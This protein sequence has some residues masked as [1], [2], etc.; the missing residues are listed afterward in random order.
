M[1]GDGNFVIY[2]PAGKPY[3]A[4]NTAGHAGAFLTVQD[5]GD[6]AIHGGS[7]VLWHSGSCCR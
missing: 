6:V 3:W 7:E 1:Q 4:S 5:D 2:D